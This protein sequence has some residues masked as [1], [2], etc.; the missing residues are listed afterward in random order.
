MC[1]ESKGKNL[2]LIL[3]SFS[4]GL[5]F[6]ISLVCSCFTKSRACSLNIRVC[7][8]FSSA[9]W[10]SSGLVV[11]QQ[12]VSS[13][14]VV[15]QQWVSS[16]LVVDQQWISSGLVVGQQWVSSGL[17]VG[18][19]EV[20][21]ALI[22]S[23][24]QRLR[25]VQKIFTRQL[26]TKQLVWTD[27]KFVWTDKKLVNDKKL[28]WTDKKLV[29]TVKELDNIG[30]MVDAV[31]GCL[32]R[33]RSRVEMRQGQ[34]EE[35]GHGQGQEYLCNQRILFVESRVHFIELRFYDLSNYLKGQ[36][37]ICISTLQAVQVMFI[38]STRNIPIYLPS[39]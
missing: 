38:G 5:S 30:K 25:A 33:G 34:G 28:V 26:V 31:R 17:V 39:Q 6:S 8:R 7:A 22:L 14:L 4:R 9:S 11:G 1:V 29:W 23:G 19:Q 20:S 3:S 16:G 12:W 18:Q 27:K 24:Q 37:T 2:T 10:V 15:G 32:A 13:G 36:N 35:Y 21:S